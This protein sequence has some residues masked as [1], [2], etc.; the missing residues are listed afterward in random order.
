MFLASSVC[1]ESQNPHKGK[2][3]C[4]CSQGIDNMDEL[5]ED[6]FENFMNLDDWSDDEDD[7]AWFPDMVEPLLQQ[8]PGQP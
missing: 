7:D 4:D 6:Q 2:K 1:L 5:V 8:A 3:V